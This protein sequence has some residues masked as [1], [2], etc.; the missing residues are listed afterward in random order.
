MYPQN[1]PNRGITRGGKTTRGVKRLRTRV[2]VLVV[3]VVF[4]SVLL[5]SL[6][7]SKLDFPV[8]PSVTSRSAATDNINIGSDPLMRFW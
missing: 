6:I 4:P 3:V 2:M 5:G 8:V 1:F 7:Y